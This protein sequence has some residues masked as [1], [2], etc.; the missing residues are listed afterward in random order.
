[1]ASRMVGAFKR[2]TGADESVPYSRPEE[3]EVKKCRIMRS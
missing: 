3:L 1:M 2:P